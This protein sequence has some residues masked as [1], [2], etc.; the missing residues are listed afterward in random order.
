MRKINPDKRW[1]EDEIDSLRFLVSESTPWNEIARQLGRTQPSVIT[2]ALRNNIKRPLVMNKRFRETICE[3]TGNPA[4]KARA[5]CHCL[6]CQTR[7]EYARARQRHL[8]QKRAIPIK[9]ITSGEPTTYD[10]ID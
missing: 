3:S 6:N 8:R 4:Y 9:Q 1:A 7:R 2:Y 10:Q 5:G